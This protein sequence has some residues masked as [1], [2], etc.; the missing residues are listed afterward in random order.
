[1]SELKL[2]DLPDNFFDI[3]SEKYDAAV[4]GDH[5]LFSGDQAVKEIIEKNSKPYQITLLETLEHRPE[6]GTKENNPFAKPEPELTILDQYG[7]D[8]EFKIIFNKF[9]VV[10]RH[11]MMITKEFKSQDTPL[12]PS[13][14]LAVYSILINLKKQDKSSDN[15]FAFFNCGPESGASQP[16]KHVQFL[17]LPENYTPNSEV[18][19][20][21]SAPF[22]PNTKQEPLQDGELLHAH[23]IAR[24]P[25]NFHDLEEDDLTMYFT[26]LLQRTL[27]VLRQ[28]NHNHISYNF[29]LTTKYMMLVPR[30]VGKYKDQLGINSC[31]VMGL[32][33]CKNKQLV[34]LVKTDGPDAVLLGVGFPNTAGEPT[35]EYHY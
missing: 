1:M 8:N 11:F 33:L 24:L 22:I 30:S 7:N 2:V 26:S 6:K 17:T 27:T 34:D 3:L 32:I 10:P 21:T 15:W 9:P 31:G 19:A 28:N 13:E 20:D 23:F 14:L 12:S 35:D 25:D 16:H 18:I 5:L 4:K 29:I